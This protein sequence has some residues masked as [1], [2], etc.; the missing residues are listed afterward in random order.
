MK[1]SDIAGIIS[2]NS[3]LVAGPLVLGVILILLFVVGIRSGIT[4]ILALR[5]KVEELKVEENTLSQKLSFLETSKD[6]ALTLADLS[7][8]AIPPDNPAL[9]I[10]SQVK[11]LAGEKGVIIENIKSTQT[12]QE[13]GSEL[14]NVELELS[15]NGPI[16]N[17]MELL[18]SF[19]SV[20]PIISVSSVKL[21]QGDTIADAKV[22]IYG[23]FSPF[24]E[25]LPSITSPLNE[26]TAE[27]KDILA[28]LSSYSQ[29]TFTEVT[30][31]GPYERADVF[32]F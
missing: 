2:A 14:G 27:E 21:N 12:V 10:I 16:T 11:K 13:E 4:Q 17:L 7:V 20:T 22:L 5:T 15:V 31:S 6:S 30:P 3:K 1:L 26:L 29:P 25:T 32:N 23:Y 8:I 24:P 18:K 9:I 19:K 28:K